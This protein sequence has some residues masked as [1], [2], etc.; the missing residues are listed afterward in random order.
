[1]NRTEVRVPFW[2]SVFRVW[3]KVSIYNLSSECKPLC[4]EIDNG[5]AFVKMDT[6]KC[7]M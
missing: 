7:K 3:F 6:K 5:Q 2:C 1:M 4:K